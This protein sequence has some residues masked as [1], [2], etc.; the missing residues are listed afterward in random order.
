MVIGVGGEGGGGG[1]RVV[2]VRR[3]GGL[4]KCGDC[5]IAFEKDGTHVPDSTPASHQAGEG[6]ARSEARQAGAA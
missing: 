5:R 4:R 2:V 6:G 3:G 1:L